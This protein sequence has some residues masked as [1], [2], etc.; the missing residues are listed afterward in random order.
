[1]SAID[2]LLAS[3][4]MDQLAAKL[5]TDEQTA[6]QATR[7]VLPSLLGQLSLNAAEPDGEM[8]LAGALDRHSGSSLFDADTLDLDQVDVHDGKKIVKHVFGSDAESALGLSG[9]GQGGL[10]TKLLPLLAPIVLAY[11]GKKIGGGGFGNILGPILSGQ[12]GNQQSGDSG[13]LGQILGQIVGG[14]GSTQQK[15]Q[16]QQSDQGGSFLDNLLG[17]LFGSR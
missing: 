4:P 5:G 16:Q 10:L 14:G 2:E 12:Q 11:L 9:S 8:S 15:K 13:I 7:E 6:E 1:M 3:I 17:G